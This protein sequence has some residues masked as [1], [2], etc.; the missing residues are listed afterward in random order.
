MISSFKKINQQENL[1]SKENKDKILKHKRRIEYFFIFI[2]S[3]FIL[4]GYLI[5]SVRIKNYTD[6]KLTHVFLVDFIS[7]LAI[8]IIPIVIITAIITLWIITIYKPKLIKFFWLMLISSVSMVLLVSDLKKYL[9]EFMYQAAIIWNKEKFL[10][11]VFLLTL[12]AL[13]LVTKKINKIILSCMKSISEVFLLSSVMYLEI[14][15]EYE[16][17]FFSRKFVSLF[18]NGLSFL[19]GIGDIFLLIF[20]TSVFISLY[21]NKIKAVI[22]FL[23]NKIKTYNQIKKIE[24]N[25]QDYPNVEIVQITDKIKMPL[26]IH[27]NLP[28]VAAVVPAFNEMNTAPAT[29]D[30][31][32]NIDYDEDK[33]FVVIVSDGSTDNTMDVL[34]TKYN[35][36]KTSIVNTTKL[37]KRNKAKSI[38]KS[39][40]YKQL[41][42]IDK[43]NGG[44]SDALNLGLEYLPTNVKYMSVIDADSIVDKYSFR[45]FATIA[46]QDDKI[47]ALTG[48]IL[49]REVRSGSNIKSSLLTNIQLFDYLSSFHG[50]RGALSLL[51]AVIIVPGAFGFFDRW[52]L[53]ELEGYPRD[54]LAE[55]GILTV[56]LHSKRD[57]IIKFVPEALSYTQVPSTFH[58]LRK[59]RM[60]WF[61]GLTE[62]LVLCKNSWKENIKLS[63]VFS[64]YL[65]V[66]WLTPV[67]I[68]IGIC[69]LVANPAMITYPIFQLFMALAVVTPMIKGVLCMCIES[70]YRKVNWR[71][72]I[73]LPLSILISPLIVLWRNDALLDLGNKNWGFIKRD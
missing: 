70:S 65:L 25:P 71:K 13:L 2:P 48:T 51:N 59:Q 12:S 62:L 31:L 34:I 30:S 63:L 39:R 38:Y 14:I 19:S 69:V 37:T 10:I 66:E 16:L 49:P 40:L 33:F 72:L 24:G 4:L 68:P 47:V 67:M 28:V 20:I 50:E 45:I 21:S 11:C 52:T 35:M 42:L 53:L 22:F 41:I 46:E 3:M 9:F 8:N 18:I 43:P 27:Q 1:F 54:V 32:L 58:D 61:K 15:G 44:K 29:I 23:N 60:R 17:F 57:V 64:E 56:N 36:Y 7:K 55:D 6:F 5:N 73:Y 26:S